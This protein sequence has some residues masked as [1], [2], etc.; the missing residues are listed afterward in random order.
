LHG[1]GLFGLFLIKRFTKRGILI[2]TSELVD[3]LLD[4][5]DLRQLMML[6]GRQLG[7]IKAGH[8]RWYFAK[9]V[10]GHF[11]FLF[12][13]A[14]RRRCHYTADRVGFLVTANLEVARRA[15]LTITVGKVLS[16]ATSID[17]V[18]EQDAQVTT[19]PM[20]RLRALFSEYPYMV[21]RIIK[22]EAF[23]DHVRELPV[24]VNAKQVVATLP[25][26]S[27]VFKFEHVVIQ[28]PAVFGDGA[29]LH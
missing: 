21:R 28:G 7:Q 8:Y 10:V 11:A 27:A 3:K 6:I 18:R 2:F 19:R 24:N 5:G 13:Q 26:Q 15:L 1:E 4:D 23:R 14:W 20:A 12:Y 29:Y 16:D 22:L 25:A 9:H 17:A